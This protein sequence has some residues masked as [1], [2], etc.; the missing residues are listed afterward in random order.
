MKEIKTYIIPL[1]VSL[2]NLACF[3]A[4]AQIVLDYDAISQAKIENQT[5][6]NTAN[7]ESSP[8][9]IGDKIGYVYTGDKN[10]FFDSQIDEPFFDIGMTEVEIDNSISNRATFYKRINSELHE[11]AMS[12]DLRSNYLY[13]TR[14]HNE[15]SVARKRDT[16]Y[17]RIMKANLND[18]NPK[19]EAISINVDKY[20]VCHPSLSSDGSSMIFSS[21]RPGSIGKMDL[22]IAYFDGD[23]WTGITN[24]GKHINTPANEIFPYFLND[25]ILVF[26]TDRTQGF[27]GL[28]MYVSHLRYGEWSPAIILPKPFNTSFDD[29]GM[30]VRPDFRSGYFTS[31]RLGGKGKDDLY[32]WSTEDAIFDKGID[33]MVAVNA[34]VVDKLNLLPIPD[35]RAKFQPLDININD[36]TLSSF[37]VDMLTGQSGSDIVLK[38]KPKDNTT[39]KLISGNSTGDLSFMLSRAKKYFIQ[40]D[41]PGYQTAAMIF[42]FNQ[43]GQE[44]NMVMEPSDTGLD[45]DDTSD[46]INAEDTIT[47]F[48]ESVDKNSPQSEIVLKQGGKYTFRNLYFDYN[49]HRLRDGAA[50]ELDAVYRFLET[51][52][53]TKIRLESHT[54][55]RGTDAYNMHLSIMRA[56]S[57]RRYLISRGI[58]ADRIDIKGYG[59]SRLLNDCTDRKVCSDADHEINRRI[60]MVII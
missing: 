22:F 50:T 42:D 7:L 13:F 5:K 2:I 1:L 23:E 60:E 21:N 34:H 46:A 48:R 26:A 3:K 38:V 40:L 4:S 9:F 11:G 49:S 57:A 55:S 30:I 44:F 54:D 53:D 16:T 24:L 36:Y 45:M 10:K 52:P 58:E 31:T 56:E 33:E 18:A 27:G 47:V 6:I 28:D 35:I 17:L 43:F 32:A 14:S 39:A 20:S 12:Y 59:E 15:R 41:A 25:S 8:A 19:V 51:S 29:F 37:N